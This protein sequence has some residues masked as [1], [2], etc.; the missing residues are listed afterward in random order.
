MRQLSTVIGVPFSV[1]DR[2][3]QST[4]CCGSVATKFIREQTPR[5]FPLAFQDLA[6]EALCRPSITTALHEDIEYI[7]ILGHGPPQVVP[8]TADLDEY[9]VD[10][11]GIAEPAFATFQGAPV[12]RPEFDTPAT[13][14][15]VRNDD[16]ALGQKVFNVTVAQSEPVVDPDCV[17]DNLWRKSVPMVAAFAF[18]HLDILSDIWST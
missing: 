10:V 2:C 12:A 15:L 14:G 1:V 9:F 3:R 16:S 13:N 6:E 4:A 7:S 8:L 5:F 18:A 17:T 11:P